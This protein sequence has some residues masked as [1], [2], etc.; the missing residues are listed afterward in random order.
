[1]YIKFIAC[2]AAGGKALITAIENGTCKKEDCIITNTTSKDVVEKYKDIFLQI[3]D[4]LKGCGKERTLAKNITMQALKNGLPIDDF[5]TTGNPDMI[6]LVTST[7][8]GSGS[9]SSTILAKYIKNVLGV[10]VHIFGFTGF[11]ADG[12]EMQN[13]IEFFQDIEEDFGVECISNEKFV[14]EDLSITD[15]ERAADNEFSDRMEVLQGLDIYDAVQNIDDTDL[16]KLSTTT[17][18][19]D[20]EYIQLPDKI[21]NAAAFNT[22][23]TEGLDNS[24]SLE[25]SIGCH[26]LGIIINCREE[27]LQYIDVHGT[28]IKE[29]FG[30]PYES[31]LHIQHESDLENF[32]AI[33]VGGMKLPMDE[34][35]AV[36]ERYKELSKQ[37]NKEKDN[38]FDTIGNLRGD[39]EDSMFN[40]NKNNK[41]VSKADFFGDI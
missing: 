5:V 15:M 34:V 9:G 14:S 40:L 11:G 41:R 37:V 27:D 26:R 39:Q 24:K 23:L 2:G 36:Y 30:M 6:V 38:F 7:S 10:N 25:T 32:I 28:K 19:M 1:M 17:R 3:G 4:S 12:R 13:T 33:I 21:K 16:Y 35:K 31:F 8:G 29:R 20:I 18:F 22:A